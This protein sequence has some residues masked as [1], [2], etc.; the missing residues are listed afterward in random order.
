MAANFD[1]FEVEGILRDEVREGQAMFLVSWKRT[2]TTEP[3]HF[4]SYT[5]EMKFLF[6]DGETFIVVWKPSWLTFDDLKD[7]ADEILGAYLL[8]KLYNFNKSCE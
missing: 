7:S 8:L 6:K 1:S 4:E 5:E 3:L 2:R